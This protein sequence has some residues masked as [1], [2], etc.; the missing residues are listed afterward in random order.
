[1]SLDWTYSGSANMTRE[2]ACA[3]SWSDTYWGG[4][5]SDRQLVAMATNQAAEVRQLAAG[6]G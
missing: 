3:E 1:M 5:F 6:V 4:A 2:L